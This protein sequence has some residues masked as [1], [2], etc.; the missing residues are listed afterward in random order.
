MAHIRVASIHSMIRTRGI[1]DLNR[2]Q[3]AKNLAA[4]EVC[5]DGGLER[6]VPLVVRG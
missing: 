3:E 6:E 1:V 4:A 5:G 2:G